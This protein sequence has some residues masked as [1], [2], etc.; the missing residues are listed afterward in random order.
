MDLLKEICV[1]IWNIKAFWEMCLNTFC[2]KKRNKTDC[3]ACRRWLW[4]SSS[5]YP[6]KQL[7]VLA[8]HLGFL[9]MHLVQ[10]FW[11]TLQHNIFSKKDVLLHPFFVKKKLEYGHKF[12]LHF[13][14]FSFPL[15]LQLM[16]LV[17]CC[18]IFEHGY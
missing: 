12:S 4:I 7:A 2:L 6:T 11:I 18:Q 14:C 8:H 1:W 3:F 17:A 13:S 5:V 15:F 16:R 10:I 9:N